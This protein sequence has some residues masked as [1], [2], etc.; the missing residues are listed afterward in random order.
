LTTL[1]FKLYVKEMEVNNVL[2]S[3]G[4]YQIEV[5]EGESYWIFLH[6]DDL[7]DVFDQFCSC[8]KTGEGR[9]CPHVEFAKEA[10]FRGYKFPLHVRFRSSLWCELFRLVATR[11][12]Y[13]SKLLKR[14]DDTYH[15]S[16]GGEK[17]AFFL[18]MKSEKA[19]EYAKEWID[20]RK[21]ETEETSLKFSNL[22]PEELEKYKKGRPSDALQ[23]ELSVWADLAKWFMI[24]EDG[25]R[26][27]LV[28]FT[29]YKKGLPEYVM[30]ESDDLESRV[31]LNPEDWPKIILPIATYKTNLKVFDFKE[32]EVNKVVYHPHQRCFSI[33]SIPLM[34][35]DKPDFEWDEWTFKKGIGF[36]PKKTN[37][38]F[39]KEKIEE[40][41]IPEFLEKHARL[42]EK[43]LDKTPFTR[44]PKSAQYELFF[45][46]KGN[47]H[48]ECY[49]FLPKDLRAEKSAFFDPWAY[50]DGKGFFRLTNLLF[51]GVEKIIPKEMMGEFIE[52]NKNWL[53]KF[54][55][56]QIH[57]SN[58]ETK[59]YYEVQ[60]DLLVIEKEDVFKEGASGVID[61]GNWVYIKGEGF[62]SRKETIQQ[63]SNLE[64]I[65]VDR[66]NVSS[67][68]HAHKDDLDH[69]KNFFS[70]DAGLEKTGLEIALEEENIVIEPKFFFK[71]W[72]KNCKPKIFGDFIFLPGKGF[73]EVP[74]NLK[75]PSKYYEKVIVSVDQIPY[76]IKHELKRLKSQVTHLDKRLMEP[77]RLKLVVKGVKKE[78]KGWLVEFF[79]TSSLGE[80]SVKEI[81]EGILSFAPFILSDAG[82][83]ALTEKRFY[84]VSRITKS[85]FEP[86]TN[87][88][89]L[90]TLDWVRLSLFE[91]VHLPDSSDPAIKEFG[92][93]LN[94]LIEEGPMADMPRLGDLKSKLR[95][96]QEVGVRW[97]WFLYTYGLS[98]FLCDEMGLGKT[99]QAMALLSAAMHEKKRSMRDKFLIVSPTSVV[100]HWQELLEKFL[101]K[102]K[103]H[104]HHGPFRNP[105]SLQL[106]HDIILT[107]YGILRSDKELFM[108]HDFE[109]AVFDEM[110]VAKNQKSQIHFALK[111]VKSEMK[112]AITGTPLENNL[113]ELK[114]L[115]DI[116]LPGFLPTQEEFKEEFVSPIEKNKDIDKQ[117]ALAKLIKP[118]ILRRK[119][120]EV[121]S[122]LPE[123]IEEIAYVD[124]SEEQARM[125]QEIALQSKKVLEEEGPG[126]YIHVFALLN[127]LKQVCD[128]PS[129]IIK[130]ENFFEKHQSGKWELFVELLEESLASNQKVVVFSQY[131]KMLDIIEIYLKKEKI[132]FAGIRG[133]T[134]DR[135]EEVSRFQQ[136]PNCKVFV[137]SLQAAGVGIDLTAASVVIHYDR[138]WNPAK[139]N[140]AT[141]R[142]HRIGQNRGISVFKF[143]AKDTIEEHIHTLIEKKKDLIANVIS[144]DNEQDLKK[145]DRNELTALLKKLYS[146]I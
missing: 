101:P 86:G 54:G 121:L 75:L 71:E 10:V 34:E 65:E 116:I 144:F 29:E 88:L 141:D 28:S 53:N 73:A 81:F 3:G 6:L 89:Y 107:T 31:Y 15:L 30:I 142:V 115:F 7:G 58:V 80:V 45:D 127:K 41:E 105:K 92:A 117:K 131:L 84:W 97:L 63:G 78:K 146:S 110:H 57:L 87:R 133:T 37:Q 12:G 136:D 17:S 62:F 94:N 21:K 5:I 69:I 82:M 85:M 26:S 111:Q 18:K 1:A 83:I 76:F 103:V 33:E 13:E 99:H 108:N 35:E 126:F 134:R 124:L 122:D 132:G 66:E 22:A 23:F 140:Q 67:F 60:D 55:E 16:L 20:E 113:L 98:G 36:F 14:E 128:H 91:E 59:F 46:T 106:K 42:V 95:P 74:D 93:I 56:F 48:I 138:W 100:Y 8:G 24:S 145:L 40:K 51:K 19:K 120:Q 50:I 2:F 135:K 68:I 139:E 129:L 25:G 123:K 96:Y 112:L 49:L 90:S 130:D 72:A 70:P 11:Y 114:A 43:Y 137:A 119:K 125:Y 47:F 9:V 104:L 39:K 79:Y 52:R 64:P 27:Y 143:V 61:L 118:F 4:T 38:F 77:L 32:I 102:A 44:K 109:I